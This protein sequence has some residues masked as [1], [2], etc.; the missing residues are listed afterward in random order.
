VIFDNIKMGFKEEGWE[1]VDGM[2]YVTDMSSCGSTK[3]SEFLE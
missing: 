1:S 3:R 2:H